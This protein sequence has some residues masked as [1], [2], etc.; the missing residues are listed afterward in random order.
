MAELNHTLSVI[1]RPGM[2][3]FDRHDLEDAIEEALGD[4][5]EV[6]GGGT[7]MDGS[8]SDISVDVGDLKSGLE[9]IRRVLQSLQ[10]PDTTRI[11]EYEPD[12]IEHL[13][14]S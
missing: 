7:M 1:F 12:R 10:V 4:T 6:T 14:Y 13:V 9:T 5:G 2:D 3:P 11:V 8:E